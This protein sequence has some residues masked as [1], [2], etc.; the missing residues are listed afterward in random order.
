MDVID[1]RSLKL[2]QGKRFGAL[3]D[4][5]TPAEW[6]APSLCEGWRNR[7]V[8]GHLV[9]GNTYP[10]VRIVAK[11]ARQRGDVPRASYLESIRRADQDEPRRLVEELVASFEHP[12]GLG[13]IIKNPDQLVDNMIHELDIR[14]S[15]GKP[16]PFEPDAMAA[17]LEALPHISS[18]FFD[19]AANARGLSLVATDLPWSHEHGHDPVVRGTGEQLLLAVG[20]REAGF[21]GLEGDGVALLRSRVRPATAAA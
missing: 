18:K 3:A 7:D 5:L 9:V 2:Q 16:H 15:V 4:E 1:Y 6:D 11:V 10:L 19:P 8:I 20:G 13:R 12:R 17:A 21:D 14:R